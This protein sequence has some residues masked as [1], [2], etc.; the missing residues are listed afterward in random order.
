MSE[1]ASAPVTGSRIASIDALRGLTIL[2]MIFVNDLAGVQGT[3][4]WMMHIPTGSDGM[5]FV[6]WVF[7]AFLFIVGMSIPFALGNRLDKGV[8]RGDLWRHVLIRTA[9]LLI[10]GVFMVNTEEIENRES[11]GAYLWIFFMYLAV[12]L[13]WNESPREPGRKRNIALTFRYAGIVSLVILAFLYRRPGASG[14]MEMQTSWWGILGL[15]G[16]AYFV[17][18]SLYLILRKQLAGM[19]GMVAILYCVYFAAQVNFFD[20]VPLLPSYVDIGG[21]LGSH[22]AISVSG[23]ILGSILTPHSPEL[24]HGARMRWAILYGL[25]LLLAGIL[26]HSLH[27]VHAMFIIDKNKATPP[28]CLISSAL[29]VWIWVA[30]YWLMDGR[31]WTRWAA[32]LSPAGK[33]PLFAYILAP[34]LY[35]LFWLIGLSGVYFDFLGGQFGLGLCRSLIFTLSVTWLTGFLYRRGLRLRL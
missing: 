12:I 14:W 35:T 26:L 30:I 7:P 5:T 18:S 25:G 17:A 24:S 13:I 6:D 21:M 15:I 10:I 20:W 9:G 32:I 4:P 16:W 33:N 3:P 22:A 29:T 8:S 19:M 34:I 27:E 28:W 1:F 11:L 2:V 23:V 31:G